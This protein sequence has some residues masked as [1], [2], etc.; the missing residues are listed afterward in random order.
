MVEVTVKFKDGHV[1]YFASDT[2]D[3]LGAMADLHEQYKGHELA[4]VAG[5]VIRTK[6]LRQGKVR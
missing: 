6:D 5:K 1:E 3:V 4:A 2:N